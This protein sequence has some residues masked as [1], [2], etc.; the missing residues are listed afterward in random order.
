[1]QPPD[2]ALQILLITKKKYFVKNTI[3]LKKGLKDYL[4]FGV[5]DRLAIAKSPLA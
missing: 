2:L 3:E 1:M 4:I 5:G